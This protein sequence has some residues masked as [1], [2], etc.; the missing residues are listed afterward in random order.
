MS[1]RENTHIR[2]LPAFEIAETVN[3]ALTEHPRLVI[4]AP[5]GAGKS[6]L[7][8]LTMLE[9][10]DGRDGSGGR[11][12]H[13]SC[14]E[15]DGRNG[16]GGH[17]GRNGRAANGRII[18]LEPRR[19]AARQIAQR[20][21]DLL[22]EA[23]GGT[24]GYRM[25]LD[26]KVSARTRIEVV[27]EGILTRMLVQDPGLEG[28]SIVL[29]D[30]FH[31]RSLTADVALALTRQA[32]ALL[33]PDLRIVLMSATMDTERLCRALDAPLVE[34]PGKM[35]PVETV[36][37]TEESN[38]M[39]AA[40]LTARAVR[41]AHAK[42]RGDIL[43]FL[44]GEG[45]IRRCA[46]LLS[47]GLGD[48]QVCPLYGMLSLTEQ[49]AAILPRSDGG[50]KIVLATPIA[51]T[52]LTIEGVTVVVDAGLY[53][54]QV[55]DPRNCMSRLETVRIS[56]DMAAQRAG[57][58]GRVAPGT[59]YR[60][61][62]PGTEMTMAP[63]R[64]PE[65]LEADLAGTVLDIAAWG[66]PFEDMPLLD[67]PEPARVAQ[68]QTL[69]QTLGALDRQGRITAH[70]RELSKLPCHPRIGR[71]LLKAATRE[72]KALAADLAALLEERDPLSAA[73]AMRAAGATGSAAETGIDLRV[74]ALRTQRQRGAGGLWGR[75]AKAARQYGRMV[76]A[77]PDQTPANSDN[78][79]ANSDHA[80]PD[81]YDMGKLLAV[82]YPERIGKA[83]QEG[84]GKFQ[85]PDG[86]I[87]AMDEA[88]TLSSSEWI[89][90]CSLNQKPGGT[91]RIFLA[92]PLALEDITDLLETR[93]RLS[94]DSKRG[95]VLAQREKR[96][97]AILAET[98]PLQD[99]PK[100]K[101]V[102]AIVE[103]AAKE[104]LSMFD[105]ADGDV[106]NLIRRI[107][108]VA[109]WHPELN[110]PD[111]R[112]EAILKRVG[113]WL[114]L[115]IGNARSAQELKK[116]DLRE[117]IWGLLSYEEQQTV[118]R[119]APA[120][121]T[122]PTGSRIKLEYRQGAEAPVV[123]VRLQECFGLTDTPKV[124]NGRLPVLMELLSPG[125]K[126]VQLTSDLRSFW[127][128]TYFEVRKELKRRYPK[129]YWPDNPLEAEAVR[130]VK[131]G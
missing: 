45:D 9:G 22:G 66:S 42:H 17:D 51:E 121:V 13:D 91:G 123:R 14:D 24:V 106:E 39:N 31:E 37:W 61:W 1:F 27:T 113:E 52:S 46:E 84:R 59:C 3:R 21:S 72:D 58:A 11:D 38:A 103:A 67:C 19:L 4:T 125:Y 50:R 81:P 7:L 76:G 70:G 2:A 107:S 74:A 122:V 56:L 86:G 118:E 40:E 30:E 126:A 47:G 90:A 109:A 79:S 33:R 130:G 85:F 128:G 111:V 64:R 68:A 94:W 34:S 35:F 63:T 75:L 78:T 60:L 73:G 96:L 65:I 131:R 100:E 25:R 48:T 87:A 102:E 80:S 26:T 5:P 127:S 53:R 71:M 20:L 89:V 18:L 54:K 83:W 41:M 112:V 62:R 6:T 95:C 44:P 16:R 10:L 8:P 117:V 97:G 55:F 108:A 36:Y 120:Y 12:G 69:L 105:F 23:V 101:R 93:D 99:V 49:R 77:E 116:I 88:D 115:Y 124:D 114:P 29:F 82:A 92:A 104:G 119:L 129:H 110:L 32:Q 28:V 43:A 15:H 57:R 98:Q